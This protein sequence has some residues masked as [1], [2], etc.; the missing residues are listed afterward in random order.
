M[1]I[2]DFVIRQVKITNTKDVV[3]P[4]LKLLL[5]AIIAD[6]IYNAIHILPC[7]YTRDAASGIRLFVISRI[8]FFSFIYVGYRIMRSAK[9]KGSLKKASIILI[10][11]GILT[12]LLNGSLFFLYYVDGPYWGKVVDADTGEPIDGA[13]VMAR[14]EIDFAVIQSSFTFAD[15]R[16]AVTDSKGRFLSISGA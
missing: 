9:R 14:W 2:M 11:F 16:E 15:A 8:L 4:L 5:L 13:N 12:C 7:L 1:K 10:S 6:E 3:I